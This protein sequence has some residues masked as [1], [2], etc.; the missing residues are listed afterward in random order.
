MRWPPWGPKSPTTTENNNNDRHSYANIIDW[1]AFAEPRTLIATGILT[2]GILGAV[3]LHR[4]YLRWFPDAGS[5]LPSYMRRRSILGRVTSVG[6]GDNFRLYHTPGGRLAGWG[7]LPWKKVPTSKKELRDKTIHVRLAGIDAP[8]LAHFGRP[9]QPFSK[10]AHEWLTAYLSNRRVRAYVHRQDQYQ[11]VVAT[12]VVRRAL[13]FPVPFRRRDVSYEMLRKGLAT[14]YEAKSGAE[15]GGAATEHKYRQAE[16][17][18]K[19]RGL[20]MWKGF[21]RNNAWES[22]RDYKTRMGLEN[23]IQLKEETKKI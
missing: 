12:V 2:T 18:A 9:A 17:W 5:I 23:P 13:D 16:W 22:P 1:R 15:F 21:R 7:W 19:L 10:E 4:R 11:R 6:D 3:A 8:E 14:V 20:G